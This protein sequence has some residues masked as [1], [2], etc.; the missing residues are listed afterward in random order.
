MARECH[1]QNPAPDLVSQLS[2]SGG[3]LPGRLDL[4]RD[5]RRSL[6]LRA[7]TLFA[8]ISRFLSNSSKPA[9]PREHSRRGDSALRVSHQTK[10]LCGLAN[11]ILKNEV[12]ILPERFQRSVKAQVN[13]E[14]QSNNGRNEVSAGQP[15]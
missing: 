6:F 9:P 7:Q 12:L 15:S 4:E 10:L 13:E 5:S 1:L 11:L 3:G 14:L 8:T 2:S